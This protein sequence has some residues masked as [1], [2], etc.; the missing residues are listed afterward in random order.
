MPGLAAFAYPRSTPSRRSKTWTHLRLE[1]P[2]VAAC[3]AK[4]GLHLVRNVQPASIGH[5]L[6]MQ[7]LHHQFFKRVT[8]A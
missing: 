5:H 6:C 1:A 7:V 8:L 2:E 4:A 3:A